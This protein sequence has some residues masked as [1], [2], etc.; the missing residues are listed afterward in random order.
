MIKLAKERGNVVLV[1]KIGSDIKSKYS[2]FYSVRYGEPNGILSKPY[3]CA[4]NEFGLDD[5]IW[6]PYRFKNDYDN[7]NSKRIGVCFFGI[8]GSN[9][10]SKFCPTKTAERIWG[11]IQSAGY[12]PFEL[13]QG[14]NF[15]KDYY[16]DGKVPDAFNLT[17]E[18][19]SLR[20]QEPNLL[21]LFNEI[22]KCKKV[23]C[24]D[25]GVLYLSLSLLGERG[26][27][28]LENQKQIQN[29]LPR[30]INIVNVKNYREGSIYNLLTTNQRRLN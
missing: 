25:N 17:N 10:E 24:V 30:S 13:Y 6:E 18:S 2:F 3:L 28:G 11:E 27:I 5:F 14:V 4:K 22:K 9:K 15:I 12:E 7:S 26:I 8:T 16:I 20:F 19:N 23:I 29:Y 21:L 1:D